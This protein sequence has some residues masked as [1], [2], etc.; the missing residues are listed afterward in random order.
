[1]EGNQY[2]IGARAGRLGE[3]LRRQWEGGKNVARLAPE[4]LQPGLG[5]SGFA[6]VRRDAS[7]SC[8]GAFRG[9]FG[10]PK[11][12]LRAFLASISLACSISKLVVGSA[13]HT[14]WL[15]TQSLT[16]HAPLCRQMR[17]TS[18]FSPRV[19]ACGLWPG[20]PPTPER[21]SGVRGGVKKRGG[22]VLE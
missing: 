21:G 10:A 14:R 11:S 5:N 18:V 2:C 13:E 17:L 8:P 16:K 7:G 22:D 19:G 6:T 4:R 1:M 3:D 20:N 15:R 12:A 9:A